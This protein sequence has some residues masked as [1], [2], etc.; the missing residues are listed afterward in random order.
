M[1]I[2]NTT[3]I[4]QARKELDNKQDKK[5]V[6][7]AQDDDF[8]RKILEDGRADVL[9]FSDFSKRRDKLKQRDSG[10]NQVLCK[11]AKKNKVDVGI[12]FK[13]IKKLGGFERA[14]YLAKVMQNIKLCKKFGVGVVL[15]NC[16]GGDKVDL[17]GF[18]LT[19]GMS[20]NMAKYGVEERFDF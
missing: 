14:G 18:L 2:I 19:L 1:K 7:I 13:E 17:K 6:V 3:N 5:L 20:T 15:V 10:L 4:N 8:N 16:R 11:I 9:L 12:D